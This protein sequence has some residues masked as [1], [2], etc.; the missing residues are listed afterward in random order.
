MMH[1][2]YIV[3]LSAMRCYALVACITF[4]VA[5]RGGGCGGGDGGGGGGGGRGGGGEGGGG[6]HRHQNG[7]DRERTAALANP[8]I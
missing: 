4:S 7:G 8:S 3:N 5:N 2:D 6:Q 1:F